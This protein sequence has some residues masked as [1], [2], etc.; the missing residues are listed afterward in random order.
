[1]EANGSSYL[2]EDCLMLRPYAPVDCSVQSTIQT[3]TVEFLK[4][5]TD[6]FD[7]LDDLSLWTKLN[8]AEYVRAV[9]ELVKWTRSLG[10]R[11]REVSI[12][13]CN[14]NENVGLHVDE[15]PVTAKINFPILNTAGSYNEWY[16][17]PKEIFDTVEPIV[18][19][20]GSAYYDLESVDL[21]QCEQVG[22]FELLQPVVFN[23]QIPHSIRMQ[24]ATDFPRLV[25]ACTFF[26]EPISF[27]SL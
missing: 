1:M 25:L 20:F 12:T 16:R 15:L 3:K 17:V 7:H 22:C 4:T 14:S 6:L 11:L 10:L 13:V 21:T 24:S 18:N 2:Y 5:K 26:E 8:T 23:S 9:P 19:E 27:L